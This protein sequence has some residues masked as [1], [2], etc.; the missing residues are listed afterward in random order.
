M[1]CLPLSTPRIIGSLVLSPPSYIVSLAGLQREGVGE[2]G[3]AQ[4]EVDDRDADVRSLL[5]TRR[6]QQVRHRRPGVRRRHPRQV[7]GRGRLHVLL[8]GE[9]ILLHC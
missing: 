4:G 7:H 5:H 6:P 9:S 3:S 1:L 8:R 2:A